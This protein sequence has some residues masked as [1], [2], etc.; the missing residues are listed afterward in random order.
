MDICARKRAEEHQRLIIGELEHRTQ[1]LFSVVQAVI[2][3]SLKDLIALI[4]INIGPT[5]FG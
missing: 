1:N 5:G 2:T 3:S 4:Q